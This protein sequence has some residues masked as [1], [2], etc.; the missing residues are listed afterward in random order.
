MLWTLLDSL[1]RLLDVDIFFLTGLHFRNY[2]IDID[3]D[4]YGYFELELISLFGM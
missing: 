2:L 1:S 3:V 4:I